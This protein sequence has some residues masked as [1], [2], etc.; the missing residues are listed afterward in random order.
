MR[1]LFV[2]LIVLL[3]VFLI[4]CKTDSEVDEVTIVL[5][6]G[7]DTIEINTS[8]TDEGVTLTSGDYS[9]TVYSDDDLNV[10][11]LGVQEIAYSVEYNEKEYSL[12]RFVTVTDQTLPVLT[13]LEGVDTIYVDG[14]WIDAGCSVEDNS[15]EVLTCSTS[16][17]ID[18]TIAGTY[19]IIY[20][21]TDS[22]NNT[23]YVERI[24]NVLE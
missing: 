9:T 20:E 5:N 10:T 18:P 23:G 22:S 24:V 7:K 1:K 8:W 21:A 19:T 17:A 11:V 16:D 12:I 15:L 14:N 3:S 13:L 4:S 2:I 6:A